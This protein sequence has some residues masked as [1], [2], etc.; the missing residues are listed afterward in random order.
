MAERLLRS[1]LGG[2]P[3]LSAGQIADLMLLAQDTEFDEHNVPTVVYPRQGLQRAAS[4][5][6]QWK[7]GLVSDK[8]DI[9]GGPGKT[10]DE[11]QWFDHCMRMAAAYATGAMDV[12]GNVQ[13]PQGIA[14]IGLTTGLST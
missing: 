6:W 8:Y 2:E 7:A 11:S 4:L 12:L 1:A 5:G 9:G 13:R 3:E 14:S 10:L